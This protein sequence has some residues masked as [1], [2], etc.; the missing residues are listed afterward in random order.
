MNYFV[1]CEKCERKCKYTIC[2]YCNKEFEDNRKNDYISVTASD[3][4]DCYEYNNCDIEFFSE[5]VGF[6]R[7]KKSEEKLSE[8]ITFCYYCRPAEYQDRLKDIKKLAIKRNLE[9][10]KINKNNVK[11]LKKIN[12]RLIK[13]Q[14]KNERSKLLI[15]KERIMS[16]YTYICNQLF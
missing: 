4:S 2:C 11:I 16:L 3:D 10:L 12:K 13:A 1:N 15:L 5:K 8:F 6:H 9:E 14:K 7:F